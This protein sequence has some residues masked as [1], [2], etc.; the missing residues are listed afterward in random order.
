[1][2]Q[3]CSTYTAA[4]PGRDGARFR[5]CRYECRNEWDNDG[6]AIDA[7]WLVFA[8]GGSRFL[9]VCVA[10]YPMYGDC[11]GAAERVWLQ[12]DGHAGCVCIKRRLDL[13]DAS[14]SDRQPGRTGEVIQWAYERYWMRLS[15]TRS[16]RW[17]NCR[18]S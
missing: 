5:L 18:T 4:D 16:R 10:L 12:V 17:L 15:K 9:C 3:Y 6:S 7:A 2:S 13:C 14:V 1:M 11:Y 8:V